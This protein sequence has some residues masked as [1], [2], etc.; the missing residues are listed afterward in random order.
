MKTH[1]ILQIS[2][3]EFEMLQYSAYLSYC[4]TKTFTDNQLQ[5]VLTSNNIFNWWHK[6]A[7]SCE[8]SFREAAAP[9]IGNMDSKSAISLYMDHL[10]RIERYFSKMLIKEALNE[11][12]RKN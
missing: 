11:N 8:E 4:D 3:E 6:E 10:E 9:F 5:M 12:S 1:E 7:K 2:P